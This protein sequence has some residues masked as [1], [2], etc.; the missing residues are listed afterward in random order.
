MVGMEPL[1]PTPPAEHHDTMKILIE[2][3]A[4][5]IVIVG[6]FVLVYQRPANAPESLATPT[7][8]TAQANPLPIGDTIGAQTQN[9]AD[10]VPSSNPFTAQA[11]PI[12][13]AYENPFK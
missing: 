9:P 11:N 12:D 10:D 7:P 6:V 2:V 4:G 1:L 3:L 8:E 13:G 5:A